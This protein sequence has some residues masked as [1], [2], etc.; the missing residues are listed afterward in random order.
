MD[1]TAGT[2][3][4]A[5]DGTIVTTISGNIS[6]ADRDGSEEVYLAVSKDDILAI[7]SFAYADFGDLT[8]L[9]FGDDEGGAWYRISPPESGNFSFE[10]IAPDTV[11]SPFSVRVVSLSRDISQKSDGNDFYTDY[12]FG[13]EQSARLNYIEYAKL[14]RL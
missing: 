9:E 11:A 12:V 4:N 8:P 1:Y 13:S 14:T 5:G 3:H 6:S 7:S 10:V 2:P